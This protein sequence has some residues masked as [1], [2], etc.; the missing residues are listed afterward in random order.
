MRQDLGRVLIIHADAA[1]DS[2]F[3]RLPGD[4]CTD[5]IGDQGG[6]FHQDCAETAGLDPVRGAADVEIDL[7]VALIRPHTGGFGE[8]LGIGPAELQGDGVF[9]RGEVKEVARVATYQGGR[10]DHFGIEQRMARH[11]AVEDATVTVG[12]IHHRSHG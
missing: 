2:D 9:G 5:A 1:F 4:Q 10:R 7:V 3:R 6:L 11:E 8:F 12:P